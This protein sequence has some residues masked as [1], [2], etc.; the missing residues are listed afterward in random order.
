M[1]NKNC[2]TA[3]SAS[4]QLW[5][6]SHQGAEGPHGPVEATPGGLFQPLLNQ[7]VSFL[8]QNPGAPAAPGGGAYVW[9]WGRSLGPQK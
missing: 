9:S 4:L 7:T 2:Q 3:G 6:H 1:D 8:L 5:D